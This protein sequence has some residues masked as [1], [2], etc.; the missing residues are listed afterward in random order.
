MAHLPDYRNQLE[1]LSSLGDLGLDSLGATTL[2][3]RN[4]IVHNA[5]RK[6]DINLSLSLLRADVEYAVGN[7]Y[8]EGKY[9]AEAVC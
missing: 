1:P 7:G 6:L 5:W 2:H 3:H 8:G 9:I 4:L